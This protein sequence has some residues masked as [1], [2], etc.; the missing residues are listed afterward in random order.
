VIQDLRFALRL[1]AK[2]RW[3][4]TVAVVSLA[5]GIGANTA[6][7]S[8]I[9][10]LML[11]Q[12]PVRESRQLVQFLSAYPGDPR[13]NVF[14]WTSYES[15][16]DR[17]RS[18]SDVVA[19]APARFAVSRDGSE[20]QTVDGE[21]VSGNFF[22]G[23]GVEPALGRML[24]PQDDRIG[25]GAAVAV[26]SWSYWSNR[27]ASD[28]AI[29]GRQ[30]LVNSVPVNVVGVA[31]QSFAGTEVAVHP[32]VWVPVAI[33]PM[34]QQP[35][36]LQADRLGVKVLAR[37]K[38]DVSI[39]QAQAEMRVLDRVWVE[40]MARRFKIPGWLQAHLDVEPA[41]AGTSV[42]REQL[43]RPLLALMAMVAVLLLLACVNIASLLLARGAARER[44]MALRV[45][46]G[47]SRLRLWRQ[48]LTESLLL[49]GAGGVL[50]IALAYAGAVALVRVLLS[51][52]PMIGL[53]TQ[54]QI[55]V[56]PDLRVLLFT[57][58]IAVLTGVLFGLAP[59]WNAFASA[60]ITRLRDAGVVGERR[61]RRVLSRGLVVAQV[62]LSVVMLSAGTLLAAHVSNLRNLNLGFQRDSVLL[63]ALDPSR[64]GYERLQLSSLYRALLARLDAIPGV[65]ASTLSGMTPISGAG[66]SRF[67]NVDGIDERPEDRRRVSL[68]PIAPQYFDTYGTPLIAGRDFSFADE[69][70]AP[71]A[72]VNQ[73]MAR[74]YFG[75]ES[76]IGRHFTFDDQTRRYEIIGV[77]A[78]AKYLNLYEAPP[79]TVYLN[80]FQEG[81]GTASD[82]ALRTGVA[83]SAVVNDVRR[84]V[85]EVLKNVPI[86]RV[87][88]L[89]EQVDA[90]IVTERLVALLS[91]AFGA[92]GALLAAIG[93][94]GL[95]AY[96]VSRRT[97]EMGLRMALGATR[98]QVMVMVWK[99]ALGLVL[100]GLAIGI[101][102]AAMSPRVL[103]R[104]M[105]Q[106]TVE[107]PM[108]LFVA[109][110]AMIAVALLAAYVPARR[111]ARVEP[112]EALR[113]A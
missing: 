1:L 71:V 7:F 102:L 3:F 73:A 66:G 62:A 111:A 18:F 44:E 49:S 70:R 48:V 89:T 108:P 83:P 6:I 53:P 60:Q 46:I 74:H 63:V 65:R 75:N 68:N 92:L 26:L 2:E 82:F 21:Y 109:A 101:P 4:T 87:T 103:A 100:A 94:Y 88:T 40:E 69:G 96:T 12:L 52:R 76:A 77:V 107:A 10:T 105:A 39:E 37:L 79:R 113:Q 51:G 23:L 41:G 78:D 98:G 14:P 36:Q 93:L 90:S 80:V 13:M 59:A 57:A 97:S 33:E 20:A 67:V 30:I 47:A 32:D 31:A 27:L 17:N 28:R 54:I 25:D 91:G 110:L 43:G 58:G 85:S 84:A 72:I 19:S 61:S 95:L 42:L 50:G 8:L 45:A 35:S 106:L 55:D 112:V 64:S 11:R 5:L 16:R 99:S 29:V 104:F 9:N 22:T 56:Q 81:R 38:P 86:R 24:G 34:V 15:F